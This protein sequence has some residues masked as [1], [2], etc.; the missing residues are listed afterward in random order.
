MTHKVTCA[1]IALWA[2]VSLTVPA[3]A[4]P[5]GNGDTTQVS[6]AVRYT[7]SDLT[8]PGGAKALASRIKD[9][10]TFVCGGDS[11]IDR[12]AIDYD[13]CRD[14]AIDGALATLKAPMVSAALGRKVPTGLASR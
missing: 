5:V 6:T 3:L 8:T 9:A 13:A 10:A 4:F 2:T 11:V 12:Q 1:G 14:N 7:A